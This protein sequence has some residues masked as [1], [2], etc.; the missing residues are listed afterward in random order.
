MADDSASA[1]HAD[2][3]GDRGAHSAAG[4]FIIVSLAMFMMTLITSTV[5]YFRDKISVIKE[6]KKR[7]GLYPLP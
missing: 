4:I 5:Q 2:R 3:H 6:K 7:A 1:R